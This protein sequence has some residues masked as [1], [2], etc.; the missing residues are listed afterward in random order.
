MALSDADVRRLVEGFGD[1]VRMLRL[2]QRL[3]QEQL[4]ER[5]DLHRSYVGQLERAERTVGIATVFRIADAL[6]VTPGELFDE[7]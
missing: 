3:S 4:A 5:A 6:G 7:D 1:R 2:A